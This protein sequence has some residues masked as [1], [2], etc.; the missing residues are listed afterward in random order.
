M[1][2]VALTF[3]VC[4]LVTVTAHRSNEDNIYKLDGNPSIHT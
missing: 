3:E 4:I 1:Y 2:R